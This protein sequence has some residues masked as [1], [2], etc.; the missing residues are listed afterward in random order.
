MRSTLSEI[1]M[2]AD[3]FMKQPTFPINKTL[4]DLFLL[5]WAGAFVAAIIFTFVNIYKK[6]TKNKIK[7]APNKLPPTIVP[8]EAFKQPIEHKKSRIRIRAAEKKAPDEVDYPI[9]AAK[10][11]E[12][13]SNII[14]KPTK[15]RNSEEKTDISPTLFSAVPALPTNIRFS[16][17]FVYPSP[18]GSR[19]QV[20]PLPGSEKSQPVAR[21]T[22]NNCSELIY[23]TQFGVLIA[24]DLPDQKHVAAHQ[25]CIKNGQ[26]VFDRRIRL[27]KTHPVRTAGDERIY[28]THQLTTEDG[29]TLH[30][31]DSVKQH[32]H[33]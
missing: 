5:A 31:L 3:P 22:I 30:L 1:T 15:R 24:D 2:K 23:N 25:R 17:E 13:L 11:E 19:Y 33:H 4:E 6:N 29:L 9:Y 26:V 12:N 27:Y 21:V 32:A 28:A 16:D 20:Y 14:T 7:S 18:E 10:Q 8:K